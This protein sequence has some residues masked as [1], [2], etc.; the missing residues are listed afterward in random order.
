[1][2]RTTLDLGSVALLSGS[3]RQIRETLE[4]I[5]EAS[6]L[7]RTINGSLISVGDP[8]FRKYRISVTSSDLWLPGLDGI[9]P[10]DIIDIAAITSLTR[11]DRGVPTFSAVTLDDGTNEIRRRIELGRIPVHGSVFA[12][13]MQNVPI[14]TIEVAGTSVY[15]SDYSDAVCVRYRPLLSCMI[16]SWSSDED[17]AAATVSWSLTALEI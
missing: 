10:G 14:P 11:V 15:I 8:S 17:E 5:G 2:K 6:Q 4:P 16:E 7:R 9:W 12:F 13:N 3:D 1:M